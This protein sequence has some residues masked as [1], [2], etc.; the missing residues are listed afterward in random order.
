MIALILND[1]QPLSKHNIEMFLALKDNASKLLLAVMESNDDT[2]NAERILY[3][4]TPKALIDVIREAYEQGKDMD[5][6]AELARRGNTF[7]NV[8]LVNKSSTSESL[9]FLYYF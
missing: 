7:Y 4:I 8:D 5:K 2:A 3:N 9:L 1:I 6:Q